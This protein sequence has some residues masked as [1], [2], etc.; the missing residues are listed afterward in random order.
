MNTIR[1]SRVAEIPEEFLTIL[2]ETGLAT[3]S[4][5]LMKNNA[6]TNVFEL[7][8][9]LVMVA[10]WKERSMHEHLPESEI[11]EILATLPDILKNIVN[12]GGVFYGPS[13]QSIAKESPKWIE[14]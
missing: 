1:N 7:A 11:H 3:L 10:W 13:S 5:Y 12:L 8:E 4:D 9:Q 2:Q 6:P 14:N